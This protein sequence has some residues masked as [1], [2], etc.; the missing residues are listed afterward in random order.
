MPKK[1]KWLVVLVSV[2]II[3][4]FLLPLLSSSEEGE[5]DPESSASYDL[6]VV[7]DDSGQ[8]R[9]SAEIDVLNE[10]EDTWETLGFYFIPNAINVE[11]T[12]TLMQ[13][14]AAAAISSVTDSGQSLPYDLENNRLLI[15][16]EEKLLPGERQRVKIDYT[17]RLPKD[18]LRLSQDGGSYFL[19]QWYPMLSFYQDGWSIEDYETKGESYHTSYG[20][21]RV[22]YDLPKE[23]FVASSADDGEIQ[24]ASSGKIEGENIKDFYLA[25]MDPE[26]WTTETTAANDTTLR[27]FFPAGSDIIEET[28]E[29]AVEAYNFFEENIGDNPSQEL[30]I[31]ANDGYME[32]PNAIEV[33]SDQENL[34]DVLVHEIGHQWFYYLVANDPFEHAWLDESITEYVTSLFLSHYYDNE[35]YGFESETAMAEYPGTNRYSN[36]PLDD[37]EETEYVATIY[38]KTPVILRDFFNERG[39]SE[40]AFDF[41]AAYYKEYQFKNVDTETFK[42]FFNEYYG[43]DYSGFFDEWL[44]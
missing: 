44:K 29:M 41:L 26:E 25:F 20:S 13:D 15:E 42:E 10:S 38:G 18:G 9:I 5:L 17:L 30:D 21:Y 1:K 32:Y 23:F 36:L 6:Q 12:P 19:A 28:A 24:T 39:G 27:M 43:E 16:L 2:F 34:E 14:S 33:A 31:I 22:T 7:L 3:L 35:D 11:E 40:E 37:Y 8:F 4:L